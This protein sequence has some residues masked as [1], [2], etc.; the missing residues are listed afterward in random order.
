MSLISIRRYRPSDQDAVMQLHTEGVE[1]IE[2][3]FSAADNGRNI[4]ADGEGASFSDDDLDHIATFY[5]NAGGDFMVGE[6]NGRV[7]AMGGLQKQS[8]TGALIRRMRTRREVRGQG[9]G[10]LLLSSL[11]RRAVQLGYTELFVDPLSTNTGARSFYENAGF[12]EMEQRM[13]GHYDIIIYR[14]QL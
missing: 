8:R 3:E 13:L 2:A 4:V 5:I 12:Q 7:V 11:E 10:A 9:Y 6:L 1:D 14:K